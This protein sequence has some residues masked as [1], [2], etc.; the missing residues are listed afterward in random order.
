MSANIQDEF[1]NIED[2]IKT[3]KN[4]EN[5]YFSNSLTLGDL[6]WERLNLGFIAKIVTH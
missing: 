5:K 3:R 2:A 6:V 1:K 4:A